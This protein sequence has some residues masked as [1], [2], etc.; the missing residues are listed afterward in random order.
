MNRVILFT[1]SLL[2][3][4]PPIIAPFSSE[5]LD[6][7]FHDKTEYFDCTTLAH[8][9]PRAASIRAEGQRKDDR[10]GAADHCLSIALFNL[11]E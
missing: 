2:T 1:F 7:H 8:G 4:S 5:L 3:F 9:D 6:S 11:G 10:S